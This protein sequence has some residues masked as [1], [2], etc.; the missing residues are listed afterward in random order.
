MEMLIDYD[1]CN[2]MGTRSN[3]IFVAIFYGHLSPKD[4]S[5]TFHH[6]QS[7]TFCKVS[8]SKL[9]LNASHTFVWRFLKINKIRIE[10]KI[11][12]CHE[13]KKQCIFCCTSLMDP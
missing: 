5:E 8:F 12:Q 11:L 7:C 4:P 3:L 2:A 13:Y 9:L 1:V 10:D 6:G